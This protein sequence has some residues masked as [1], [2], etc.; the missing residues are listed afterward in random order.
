MAELSQLDKFTLSYKGFQNCT[1]GIGYGKYDIVSMTL[2]EFIPSQRESSK[3]V[4]I[5]AIELQYRRRWD[6]FTPGNQIRFGTQRKDNR[7]PDRLSLQLLD[8]YLRKNNLSLN[9]GRRWDTYK[10]FNLIL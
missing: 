8:M 2:F 3:N 6:C 1:Y 7:S 10:M 4:V 5:A 9:D